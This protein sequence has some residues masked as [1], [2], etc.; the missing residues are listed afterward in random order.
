M[1]EIVGVRFRRAGKI[2]Y[3]DPAGLELKVNDPV[4]VETTRGPELGK[5]IIAPRQLPDNEVTE[6]LK[7]VI[8]KAIPEDIQR[9]E[10]LDKK[11]EEAL[12]QCGKMIAE[13]NLP[14]K[15]LSAEYN[16]DGTHL[17]F[18]FSAEQRVDFRELLRR[19]TRQFQTRIELRQVGARD[20]A[21]IVGG[22]GRCGRHLCC[23]SFIDEF[24]PISIKMAKDQDLPLNP[25]KISGICGRLMCCLS[26]EDEFYK[27]AKEKMPRIGQTVRTPMGEA[28]VIDLNPLKETVRVTLDSEAT[29]E[30]PLNKITFQPVEKK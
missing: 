15:L 24:A 9:A 20:E 14:M 19:L 21:K 26:Y 4:I 10:E 30:L 13:L 28:K 11:A 22:Y 25:M 3:F 27:Q 18:M 29:V 1:A 8:R 12:I 23:A 6:P 2:Y 7:P 17:T 5:V 16:S